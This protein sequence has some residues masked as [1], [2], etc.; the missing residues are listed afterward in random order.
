MVGLW[1][2]RKFEILGSDKVGFERVDLGWVLPPA[3][4]NTFA[5]LVAF[6]VGAGLVIV[7]LNYDRAKAQKKGG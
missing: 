6:L 1:P 5:T 3:D 2:F 7:F 4:W